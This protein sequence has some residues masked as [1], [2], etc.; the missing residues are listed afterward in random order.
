MKQ[1]LI[2][3][4][5][6]DLQ[7]L[8]AVRHEI[9]TH[10]APLAQTPLEQT[11]ARMVNQVLGYLIER[12]DT[13]PVGT[14][15]EINAWLDLLH[16]AT[17]LA[18][19]LGVPGFE[20]PVTMAGMKAAPG[21][22][23]EHVRSL[24]ESL[25]SLQLSGDEVAEV[26]KLAEKLTHIHAKAETATQAAMAQGEARYREARLAAQGE[27]TVAKLEAYLRA[28][29]PDRPPVKLS[30]LRELTGGF[31]KTTIMFDAEGFEDKPCSLVLKRDMIASAT[32][33]SAVDEFPML[34]TLHQLGFPVPEPLWIETS[35]D[36]LSYPFLAMRKADGEIGGT[37]WTSGGNC[38]RQTALD[39]AEWLGK[40]H[41]LDA[42][43]LDLGAA[44]KTSLNP[45]DEML[46]EIERFRQL[47]YSTRLNH[48]PLLAA[49]M[50]WLERNIP[51]LPPRLSIIHGDP[52]FH[53]IL[54]K[55]GRL[56]AILDWELSHL[57][58]PVENL[59]Y[60]RPHIER[61]IPWDEFLAAYQSHG[62]GPYNEQSARYYRV[63]RG[64]RLSV[65]TLLASR[66]FVTDTNTE[67]RMGH[68]GMA[69]YRMLLLETGAMFEA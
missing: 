8:R 9:A 44:F 56:S 38:T 53:N 23:M 50:A 32:N 34:K 67:L 35:S 27:V 31:S 30:N 13:G 60:I 24:L 11:T 18:V 1:A 16:E 14:P 46:A 69:V 68:C 39:V 5:P 21:A 25:F 66:G 6:D 54:V 49:S 20:T 19:R 64:M 29:F 41:A 65:M 47:W 12:H 55:N 3:G 28:R 33:T 58:D 57:G 7:V 4:A 15:D 17:P 40:L 42:T 48:D 61:L 43:P 26:E 22:T 37:M 52:G 10:L 62:G 36:A 51:P 45:R 59:C 2:P 63:W